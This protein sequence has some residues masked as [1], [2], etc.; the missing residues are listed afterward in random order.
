MAQIQYVI[1]LSDWTK[2]RGYRGS[3]RGWRLYVGCYDPNDW[4]SGNTHISEQFFRSRDKAVRE[5]ERAAE[6]YGVEAKIFS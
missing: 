5:A 4:N 3:G 2:P 1:T 6:V